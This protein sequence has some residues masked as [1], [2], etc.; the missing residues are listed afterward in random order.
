MLIPQVSRE[1]SYN[2]A[3]LGIPLLIVVVAWAISC[4]LPEDFGKEEEND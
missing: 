3:T 2:V 4:W 1:F